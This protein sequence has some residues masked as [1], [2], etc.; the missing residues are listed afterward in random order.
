[1]KGTGITRYGGDAYLDV[2]GHE[3][4]KDFF[5]FAAITTHTP[6]RVLLAG[7][8]LAGLGKKPTRLGPDMQRY[9]NTV[10]S[11]FTVTRENV[12]ALWTGL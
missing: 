2:E 7:I 6:P 4:F 9:K 8:S 3:V 10:P 1:M 5:V 11:G 12:A